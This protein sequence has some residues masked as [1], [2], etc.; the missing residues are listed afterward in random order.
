[1]KTVATIAQ[2]HLLPSAQRAVRAILPGSS[3]GSLASVAS[4]PDEVRDKDEWKWSKPLHFVNAK[5]D[6]PPQNC[7]F[8]EFGWLSEGNVFNAIVNMTRNLDRL[9]GDTQD[10]ALRFLTHFFGDVHQPL[11]LTGRYF[12]ANMV[13]VIYNGKNTNLHSV[14]DDDLILHRIRTLTNYTTPL[15][16]SP[17]PSL[18]PPL[19]VR[20]KHIESALKGANYDP[21]VRWIVLE[22]IYG[23]WANELD[24]W[25]TCPQLDV[26]GQSQD[27][28][29][30]KN[31]PFEDPTD[32]RVCPYHWSAPAHQLICDFIWRPDFTGI[33]KG[34]T[35]V[36]KIELEPE[37]GDQV[38]NK[39]IIEKQLALGGMRLA[40]VLNE[41]LGSEEDKQL[42]GVLPRLF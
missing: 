32:V 19:L 29:T 18:P 41:V 17:T 20:N 5:N 22:G 31:P 38:R 33:E 25:T 16:T 1:H 9:T 24:E 42:F 39:K 15:P 30:M 34:E 3:N 4:W 35:P 11:H 8:G 27:Q 13:P 12:G 10:Q 23:W 37:Y 14:W 28:Q 21:L 26:Q 7:A 36:W 40:A 2:I 6:F